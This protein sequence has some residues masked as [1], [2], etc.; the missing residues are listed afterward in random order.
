MIRA[1]YIPD[2]SDRRG[3]NVN[4]FA[5]IFT[6][7]TTGQLSAAEIIRARGEVLE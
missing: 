5:A 4:G 6:S 1:S 7:A 3:I 2:S